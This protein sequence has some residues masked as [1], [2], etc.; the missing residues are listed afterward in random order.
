MRW[1]QFIIIVIVNIAVLYPFVRW[2]TSAPKTVHDCQDTD[3]A[4]KTMYQAGVN[5]CNG[6][7]RGELDFDQ[8]SG[9]PTVV[10]NH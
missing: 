5:S 4:A 6:Q 9:K 8:N 1:K 3:A 10:C 2:Q 7:W